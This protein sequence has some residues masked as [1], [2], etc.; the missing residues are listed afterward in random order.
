MKISKQGIDLIKRLEGCVLK[1]YLDPKGI[2]TCGYGHTGTELNTIPVGTPVS[3]QLADAYLVSDLEKFEKK[4]NKYAKYNFTQNEFDA[5]VSFCYNVGNIDQLTD[6]GKRSKSV[7]A[8]KI[9]LYVKCGNKV[10]KGLVDRRQAEHDLFV[11]SKATTT[12]TKKVMIGH[13]SID[14]HGKAKNGKA[15]DQSGKEVCIRSWYSKPWD[16]V[17]RCKDST[18]AELMAQ[19]CEKACNNPHIGYDQNQRNTLRTQAK[20]NNWDLS[21]ITVDCETDCSAFMSV[22]AECAGI[23]IP[24]N[25]TNAPTT[26]T[27]QTAFAKTGYFDVITIKDYLDSDKYLKRGDILV[28][29]GSHTVMV[30]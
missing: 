27:M 24:Y 3:Q 9:L 19:A 1:V 20:E 23:S 6:Y 12:T 16:M 25:G 4:V 13:A 15:G 26:R 22:C 11:G 14:E 29:Q 8:E 2:K 18:K 17:L 7:I 30:L 28:K 10:L 21:K 5:L